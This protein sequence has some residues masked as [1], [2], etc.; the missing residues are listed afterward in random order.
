MFSSS[1]D[2]GVTGIFD[3]TLIRRPSWRWTWRRRRRWLAVAIGSTTDGY[4][5]IRRYDYFPITAFPLSFSIPGQIGGDFRAVSL[6]YRPTCQE[7]R[8]KSEKL[9]DCKKM[10]KMKTINLMTFTLTTMMSCAW[11]VNM[12]NFCK[13]KRRHVPNYI[14]LFASRV[15]GRFFVG[16]D[17][18]LR[19]G[20]L[21]RS[22]VC[23]IAGPT[24]LAL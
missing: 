6:M 14:T 18:R 10:K 11:Q 19:I 12:L 21:I 2:R 23:I 16:D 17:G 15:C 5:I 7:L 3:G 8:K 1:G 20:F 4:R 24:W 13:E 9:T 22:I